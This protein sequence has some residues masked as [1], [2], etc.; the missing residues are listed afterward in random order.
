MEIE[1]F[2]YYL[3]ATGIISIIISLIGNFLSPVDLPT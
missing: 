1:V 3:T 2:N